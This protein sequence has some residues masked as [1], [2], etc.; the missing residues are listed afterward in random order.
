MTPVTVL[1]ATAALVGGVLTG[2]PAAADPP[3]DPI[4]GLAGELVGPHREGHRERQRRDLGHTHAGDG[5][6]RMG[7]HDYP[8]RYRLNIRTDDWT[9][10]TYLD[11]RR[12]ET[13]ASGAFSADAD[14]KRQRSVF[15][16]CRYGTV[17][18][19]FT[20]R[21]KLHWYTGS[22]E[23]KAWLEPSHFRLRRP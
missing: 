11:D 3:P 13:I 5:V 21:A 1:L 4:S 2:V 16:L 12:A 19:K 23:H 8:Y 15:R 9:L 7:C 6:L 10:E 14:R 20:I 22:G 18:G 17:P